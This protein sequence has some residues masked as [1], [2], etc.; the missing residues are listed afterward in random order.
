MDISKAKYVD[1]NGINTR[2]FEA[3]SGEPMVLIHGAAAGNSSSAEVWS[4]NFDTF[5]E[6][7]HVYAFDKLGQG[8]TDNPK[9]NEDYFMGGQVKHAAEFMETLG[10]SNAHLIG[11]S[12][13]GYL[14]LIHI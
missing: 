13:G 5:A 8:Y 7:Y 3:G 2:Y 14:S 11:H 4:K 9:I 1:V 12:R 10:I 6:K